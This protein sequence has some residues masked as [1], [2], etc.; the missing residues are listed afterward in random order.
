MRR[1]RADH[2]RR[3]SQLDHGEIQR[4]VAEGETF[5]S[6]AEAVGCSTKSIQRFMAR[7]G[8]LMRRARER[9]P[10]RLSLAD[11]EELSRGLLAGNSLR[12]IAAQLGRAVS[13]I[14]REVA[15]NGPR[16]AHR[17]RRAERTAARRARRPKPAKLAIQFPAVP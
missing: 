5:A 14:S 15:W 13:T 12:R 2:G 4:R 17:A 7:T 8:G 9:S 1:R 10:L 11:R 6:A 16:D 3:L